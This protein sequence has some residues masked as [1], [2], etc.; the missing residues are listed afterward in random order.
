MSR[1][2]KRQRRRPFL[3]GKQGPDRGMVD[4]RAGM[5]AGRD[6]IVLKRFLEFSRVVP[7]ARH[8]TPLPSKGRGEPFRAVR[9]GTQVL[10]KSMPVRL[11]F[12]FAAVREMVHRSIFYVAVPI[13][14]AERRPI[15]APSKRSGDDV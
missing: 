2:Y 6:E 11:R 9:R 7:K 10:I 15:K 3:P 8:T 13:G 1:H 12:V 4:F 14:L 5:I